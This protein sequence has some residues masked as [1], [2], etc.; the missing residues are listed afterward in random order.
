MT[1]S[2]LINDSYYQRK[3]FS[4]T[5]QTLLSYLQLNS[6]NNDTINQ[7]GQ[8]FLSLPHNNNLRDSFRR[9][10]R[11]VC[12][13][14]INRAPHAQTSYNRTVPVEKIKYFGDGGKMTTNGGF[15]RETVTSGPHLRK[16]GPNVTMKSPF[17][18]WLIILWVVLCS[19]FMFTCFVRSRTDSGFEFSLFETAGG[20]YRGFPV[21]Q[22]ESRENLKIQV[23]T[24]EQE[25]MMY[26]HGSI[27]SEHH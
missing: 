6:H 26:V 24:K 5:W 17:S 1:T 18:P 20:A 27:A 12:P 15:S 19:V 8:Q 3:S 16:C 14:F 25:K 2:T 22:S 13:P 21:R 11:K 9:Q 7:C 23:K 10:S 4:H